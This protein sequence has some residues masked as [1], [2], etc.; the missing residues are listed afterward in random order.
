MK[1]YLN[2]FKNLKMKEEPYISSF[3]EICSN[4]FTFYESKHHFYL[5]MDK[6]IENIDI[7]NWLKT[8]EIFFDRTQ[9]DLNIISGFVDTRN[10]T[11]YGVYVILDDFDKEF[12]LYQKLKTDTLI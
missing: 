8:K 6:Y 3:E 1:F 12:I 7:I 9:V 4:S 5:V 10:V 2:F 11:I